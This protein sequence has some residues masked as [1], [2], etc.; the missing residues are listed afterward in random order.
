MHIIPGSRMLANA[1][2]G[3]YREFCDVHGFELA[4]YK[5]TIPSNQVKVIDN[6]RKWLY[7][8]EANQRWPTQK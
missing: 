7:V 5:G 2:L 3:D 6:K 8:N 1:M 4:C